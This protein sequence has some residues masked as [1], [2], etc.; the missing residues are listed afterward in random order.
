MDI[1]DTSYGAC[2][3]PGILLDLLHILSPNF[4]PV[5]TFLLILTAH[6]FKCRPGADQLR[7]L[8]NSLLSTFPFTFC[9][10]PSWCLFHETH[11]ASQKIRVFQWCFHRS[12]LNWRPIKM[13]TLC[14]SGLHHI[15]WVSDERQNVW[16]SQSSVWFLLCMRQICLMSWYKWAYITFSHWSLQFGLLQHTS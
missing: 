13:F 5:P 3:L 7:K 6:V 10:V 14:R 15:L 1:V 8:D 4:R 16:A 2:K 11:K 12:L 9:S